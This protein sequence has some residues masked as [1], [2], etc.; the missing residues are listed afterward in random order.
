M[1]KFQ[2]GDRVI[3]KHNAEDISDPKDL[4]FNPKMRDYLEREAEIIFVF[5]NGKDF[6]AHYNIDLDGG[7]WTW[8]ERWLDEAVHYPDFEVNESEFDSIFS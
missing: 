1:A 3:I 4:Y 6:V 8:S 5:N 7:E 2:I